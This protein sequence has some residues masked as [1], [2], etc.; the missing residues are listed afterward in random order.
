MRTKRRGKRR[1]S[2]A[3]STER[4]RWVVIV[5]VQG[6]GPGLD[7]E[8]KVLTVLNPTPGGGMLCVSHL[9]SVFFSGLQDAEGVQ[10]CG[11]VRVDDDAQGDLGL[12]EDAVVCAGRPGQGY[13]VRFL[14]NY[15]TANLHV[16]R[17]ALFRADRDNTILVIFPRPILNLCVKI[18]SPAPPFSFPCLLL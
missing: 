15:C 13:S 8:A 9:D 3:A 2:R 11:R 18:A 12:A 14:R 6:A 7:G 16:V 10:G 5:F 1:R 17:D 4:S